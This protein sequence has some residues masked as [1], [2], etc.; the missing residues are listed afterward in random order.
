[1]WRRRGPWGP[2]R[3]LWGRAGPDRFFKDGTSDRALGGGL[4]DFLRHDAMSDRLLRR[5]LSPRATVAPSDRD[6]ARGPGLPGL[7][8]DLEKLGGFHSFGTGAPTRDVTREAEVGPLSRPT[9][10]HYRKVDHRCL[11]GLP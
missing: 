3:R 9:P 5:Y 4:R 8:H 11:T 10:P 2:L 6:A 7:A 1:M